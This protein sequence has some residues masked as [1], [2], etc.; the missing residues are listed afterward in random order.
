[1]L[2]IRKDT[3]KIES[4]NDKGRCETMKGIFGKKIDEKTLTVPQRI[5]GKRK[6]LFQKLF[7]PFNNTHFVFYQA[8]KH[9]I[10]VSS[11]SSVKYSSSFTLTLPRQNLFLKL[12]K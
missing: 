12:V 1:M 7:K 11:L 8:E 10:R 4:I 2:N 6:D 9:S 5:W 3:E